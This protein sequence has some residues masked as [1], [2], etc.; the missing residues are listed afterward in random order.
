MKPAGEDIAEF[1]VTLV[2]SGAIPKLRHIHFL[3]ISMG[4]HVAGATG[5]EIEKLTGGDK[6][7]RITG[8]DPAGPGF[9]SWD[10][11]KPDDMTIVLDADDAEFV[12]VPINILKQKLNVQKNFII[13][14]VILNFLDNAY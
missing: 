12:D 10:G 8:L 5:Y 4:A 6:L 13:F 1:F 2:R 3:G 11:K 7:G 14:S 9:T